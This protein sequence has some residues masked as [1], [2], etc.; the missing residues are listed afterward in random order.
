[1]SYRISLDDRKENNDRLKRDYRGDDA[2]CRMSGTGSKEK[3]NFASDLAAIL[4]L[5]FNH[6]QKRP[7]LI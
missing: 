1:M 6:E 3:I 5:K 7:M 4:G 2:G